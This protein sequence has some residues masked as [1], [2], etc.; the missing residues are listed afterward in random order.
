MAQQPYPWNRFY[1]W[2]NRQPDRASAGDMTFNRNVIVLFMRDRHP[3]MQFC[4][5][6][7]NFTVCRGDEIQYGLAPA[8]A[9]LLY[10]KL[11]HIS[12]ERNVDRFQMITVKK[13][14]A[15]VSAELRGKGE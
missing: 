4:F 7:D 3:D 1:R 13:A 14:M 11:S 9:R 12:N 2:L 6:D 10:R 5:C 8:W 15:E